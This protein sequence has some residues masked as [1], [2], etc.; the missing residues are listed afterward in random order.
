MAMSKPDL[1]LATW[2][3]WWGPELA[4]QIA[5]SLKNYVDPKLLPGGGRLLTKMEFRSEDLRN[6]FIGSIVEGLCKSYPLDRQPSAYLL[7]DAI[8]SLD[9]LLNHGLL[10]SSNGNP[11]TEK[12][13]RDDALAE[14][15]RLKKLLSYVRLS[16]AKSD[17]GRSSDVTYLKQLANHR[18]KRSHSRHSAL[19]STS[20]TVTPVSPQASSP[21]CS[22]P[23]GLFIFFSVPEFCHIYVHSNC[24]IC[25]VSSRS[26]KY[27][28][29]TKSN[30]R[31]YFPWVPQPFP[32]SGKLRRATPWMLILPSS[33]RLC[34][35]WGSLLQGIMDHG[36][37]LLQQQTKN[38]DLVYH[39][40]F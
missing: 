31:K 4:D 6:P 27:G 37:H 25:I 22:S 10:R 35:S 29:P 36:H 32:S 18:I 3:V 13:R 19:S 5:L 7:G 34:S 2:K 24:H 28:T 30:H 21:A 40:I 38:T 1:P 23:L 17:V 12:L 26:H 9:R 8:L 15:G 33:T 20:G 11:I 14:G 16:G 39:G